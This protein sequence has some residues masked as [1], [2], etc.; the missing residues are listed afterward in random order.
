[1][2]PIANGFAYM[3]G[4]TT[5]KFL[6]DQR[7][8][9]PAV[10]TLLFHKRPPEELYAI[11]TDPACLHNLATDSAYQQ[12]LISLRTKLEQQLIAQGDPRMTTGSE[13][14]ESYPRFGKMRPFPG[15][16]E[17]GAYNQIGR[18]HV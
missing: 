1:M 6:L 15:F 18:A 4:S 3:D 16:R 13:V 8:Q 2:M 7:A 14:F 11:K 10:D 9:W 5:K 12:I 17:E